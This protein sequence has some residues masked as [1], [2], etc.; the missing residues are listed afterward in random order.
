MSL[1]IWPCHYLPFS[2]FTSSSWHLHLSLSCTS[3]SQPSDT[4]HQSECG[5][6]ECRP[7]PWHT[8]WRMAFLI[9]GSHLVLHNSRLRNCHSA[10]CLLHKTDA[11]E[12]LWLLSTA[13]ESWLKCWPVSHQ[14]ADC[15][16]NNGSNDWDGLPVLG[17]L[18]VLPVQSSWKSWRNVCRGT[19]H[20]GGLWRLCRWLG[21]CMT[22][23][24]HHEMSL[25]FYFYR[26]LEM[27][28]FSWYAKET[29]S[30]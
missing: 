6:L 7:P 25:L 26:F 12:P 10:L 15:D 3:S 16:G 11:K 27:L 2:P 19:R 17:L 14:A 9:F 24:Y 4:T 28:C 5:C 1:L 30:D 18:W 20:I 29:L 22:N 8:E 23:R 13:E 21:T